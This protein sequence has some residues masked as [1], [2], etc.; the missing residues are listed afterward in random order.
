MTTGFT[1]IY[2]FWIINTYYSSPRL[3]LARCGLTSPLVGLRQNER[4]RGH[5]FS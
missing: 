3:G 5:D 2:K 4:F 1:Y